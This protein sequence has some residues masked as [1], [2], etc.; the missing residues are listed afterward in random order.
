MVLGWFL[1]V[2]TGLRPGICGLAALCVECVGFA[3]ARAH[4]IYFNSSN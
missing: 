1:Q 4:A 2:N 3:H